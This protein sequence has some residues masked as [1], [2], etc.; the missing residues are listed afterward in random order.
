M[1]TASKDQI[2]A[3][4]AAVRESLTSEDAEAI[5]A[6]TAELQ[7]A[8]HKVSEAM[9]ERAQA[10]AQ[11]EGAGNGAGWGPRCGTP[12]SRSATPAAR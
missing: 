12:A 4:I 2:E 3:A 6:R 8:F 9:Y 5:N 7:S 1:D 11:A 10:Q